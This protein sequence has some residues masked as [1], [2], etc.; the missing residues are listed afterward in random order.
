MAPSEVTGRCT[1]CIKLRKECIFHPVDQTPTDTRGRHHPVTL[2]DRMGLGSLAPSGV[3]PSSVPSQSYPADANSQLRY[4]SGMDHNTSVPGYSISSGCSYGVMGSGEFSFTSFSFVFP[5]FLCHLSIPTS[6]AWMNTATLPS[7]YSSH[8]DPTSWNPSL[9]STPS[10]DASS[11]ASSWNQSKSVSPQFNSS[12][13]V[14]NG[15]YPPH[16]GYIPPSSHRAYPLASPSQLSSQ[17]MP[18]SYDSSYQPQYRVGGSSRPL[19]SSS[20]FL[21]PPQGHHH[22]VSSRSQL[23]S[24]I[25]SSSNSSSIPLSFSNNTIITGL[26]VQSENVSPGVGPF[27]DTLGNE[28]SE[29]SHAPVVPSQ[30]YRSDISSSGKATSS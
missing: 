28:V 10:L 7:Q 29:Q 11:T 4:I 23:P 30:W 5:S 20:S 8:P 17:Y 24:D 21:P 3:N 9:L 22:G 13:P 12:S 6:N 26:G 2:V 19:S 27:W 18:Y 16:T 15:Q 14:S 1:N 25:T